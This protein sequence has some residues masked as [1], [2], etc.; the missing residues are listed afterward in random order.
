MGGNVRKIKTDKKIIDGKVYEFELADI[1]SRPGRWS[2]QRAYIFLTATII[3]YALMTI[4]IFWMRQAKLFDFSWHSYAITYHKTL[5]DYLFYPISIH[6]APVLIPIWGMLMATIIVVPILISQFY[7]FRFSIVFSLCVLF[8]AHL[9]VLCLFLIISSFIAGVS[10]QRLPFK[11]GVA[12]L[13]L[14]PL[15]LYFIVATRGETMLQFKPV[16]SILLYAPW[17]LAFLAAAVIAAT[18]LSFARLV[19]YRPG[20]ILIGMIPFCAIPVVLFY[21]YIG[22][23]QLEFRLIA[24]RVGPDSSIFSPVDISAQVFQETLKNWRRY[25]VR[26]LQAIVDFVQIDFPY[27]AQ[28]LTQEDRTKILIACERFLKKYPHSRFVPNALYLMAM[29]LD[30]RFDYG[31]LLKYWTV[32]YTTDLV[33]PTSRETWQRLAR[34]YPNSIYAEEALLRLAVLA[35]RD[36]RTGEAKNLL[37][38]LLSRDSSSKKNVSTQPADPPMSV[39]EFFREPR[40]IDIP[41]VDL[42]SLAEQAQELRELIIHNENDPR[43]GSVPLME[44][45]RLDPSHPQYRDHLL[46][47]AGE[48]STSTLHDDLMVRYALTDPDPLKR[49]SLLERYAEHRNGQGAGAKA[50]FELASLLKAWGLVNMDPKAHALAGDYFRKLIKQYPNSIFAARARASLKQMENI[51]VQLNE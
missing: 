7:G 18:V 28:Q 50:L 32:E 26:D 9:P 39:R 13:S 14:F 31:V 2:R 22:S 45:M 15:G 29:A 36:G 33:S 40:L 37:N 20:G 30:L 19:K 12:L 23:D 17:I 27:I 3:L 41:P 48:Y 47:M 34:D 24:Q 46:E 25:K 49:K 38:Q 51:S 6:D 1:W 35:L 8:L 44:L 11:F 4:F 10:K 42:P 21:H 5:I 43:F 16:D